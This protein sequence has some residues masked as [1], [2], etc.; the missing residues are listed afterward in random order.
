M[1]GNTLRRVPVVILV[2]VAAVAVMAGLA[3]CDGGTGHA[4]GTGATRTAGMAAQT[5]QVSAVKLR[6][7]LLT[8][9]NGAGAAAPA[10]NGSYPALAV[11]RAASQQARGGS[12]TPQACAQMTLTS[13]NSAVLASAPAAA[14]TF[15]V[16][17]NGVSEVLAAAAGPVAASAL[18]RP[19]AA[20]CGHY[21]ARIAGA[22][23]RYTATEAAVDGIGMQARVL[24]V[25][26]AGKPADD[27]WSIVYRGKEFVGAVIV[28]GPDASEAAVRELGQQAYA[29][30]AS[31]LS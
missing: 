27:A 7:A 23:V 11:V 8:Q 26:T 21:Q 20:K 12:V 22:T 18:A 2:P 31:K 29:Y 19:A 1:V 14:V 13:L 5:A 9:V 24:N 6:S 10:Q 15:R 28:T 3:G 17:P 25:Q 30:A 16:G 4:S